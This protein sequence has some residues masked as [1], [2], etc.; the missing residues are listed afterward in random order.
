MQLQFEP[1]I[2]NV[3]L[4]THDYESFRDALSVYETNLYR[5]AEQAI[6]DSTEFQDFTS[7]EISL[8]DIVEG[9]YRI[10]FE[11]FALRPTDMGVGE[12]LETLIDESIRRAIGA[13]FVNGK[14]LRR[15]RFNFSVRVL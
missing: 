14:S 13:T 5:K 2:D 4:G 8:C 12:W 7:E 9:V 6:D 15:I 10:A 3:Y 1:D 11:R